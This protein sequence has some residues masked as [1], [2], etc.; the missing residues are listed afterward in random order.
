VAPFRHQRVSE[1]VP[2]DCARAAACI[3]G[4]RPV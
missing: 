4:Q 2:A 1:A 3:R